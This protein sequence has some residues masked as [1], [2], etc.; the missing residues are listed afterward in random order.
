MV[1][2]F[3]ASTMTGSR[4]SPVKYLLRGLAWLFFVIAV[5]AFWMGGRAIHEFANTE[6]VPA[7][8][9]GILV[10][11]LFGGLGAIAKSFADRFDEP[12]S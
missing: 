5:L 10:A 6:R 12:H 8:M 9:G 7:E 11:V 4:K 3:G 2:Y 1:R